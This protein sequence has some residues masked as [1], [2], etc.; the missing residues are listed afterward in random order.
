MLVLTAWE[1]NVTAGSAAAVAA[2]L[3]LEVVVF[4]NVQ[5]QNAAWKQGWESS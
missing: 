4:T 3:A 2:E 1:R 5:F